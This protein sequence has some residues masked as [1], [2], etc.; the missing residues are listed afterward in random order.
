MRV[1]GLE[2]KRMGVAW[3]ATRKGIS[4]RVNFAKEN[5]MEKGFS[6]GQMAKFSKGNGTW[7]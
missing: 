1:N 2:I 5:R 4:M 7:V 6:L 3:N